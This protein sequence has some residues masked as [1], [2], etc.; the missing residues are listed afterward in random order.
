MSY[1]KVKDLKVSEVM[2]EEQYN[3]LRETVFLS[4]LTEVLSGDSEKRESAVFEQK[5]ILN[6]VFGMSEQEIEK[7]IEGF[8]YY[9]S[10]KQ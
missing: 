1:T 7:R 3:A 9:Q 6:Q 4:V 8:L 5:E 10:K 2:T